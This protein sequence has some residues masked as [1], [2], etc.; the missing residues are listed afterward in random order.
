MSLMP[1]AP[2]RSSFCGFAQTLQ[3]QTRHDHLGKGS[4]QLFCHCEMA[5]AT[6]LLWVILKGMARPRHRKKMKQPEEEGGPA[7]T[8]SSRNAVAS[9]RLMIVTLVS[10]GASVTSAALQ[11]WQSCA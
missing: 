4:V 8:F 1:Q 6:V 7:P 10:C 11:H 5:V 2:L 9:E 3:R